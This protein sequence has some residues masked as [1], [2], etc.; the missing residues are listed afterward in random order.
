MCEYGGLIKFAVRKVLEEHYARRILIVAHC[1][2]NQS[3]CLRG[4]RR[5]SPLQHPTNNVYIWFHSITN[6]HTFIHIIF[7]EYNPAKDYSCQVSQI[8][9]IISFFKALKPPYMHADERVWINIG[10]LMV[11]NCEYDCCISLL[12]VPAKEHHVAEA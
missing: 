6:S 10:Q 2:S 1:K 4:N 3:S 5:S 12:E 9:Y 7:F 8:N 11:E